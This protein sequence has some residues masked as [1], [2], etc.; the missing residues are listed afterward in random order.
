MGEV[1][2]SLPADVV[3]SPAPNTQVLSEYLLGVALDNL[4]LH[5][6]A[7]TH[8]LLHFC[9]IVTRRVSQ[10]GASISLTPVYP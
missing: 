2:R 5:S 8:I 4:D 6:E 1:S 7:V 3:V 10:F 9:L